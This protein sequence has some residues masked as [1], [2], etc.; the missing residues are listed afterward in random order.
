MG[1]SN[2]TDRRHLVIVGASFS[3]MNLVLQVQKYFKITLIDK[4]E[5]F[6]WTCGTPQ[7][8]L[9]DPEYFENNV[10]AD[11]DQ[12][13]NIDR[14]YGPNVTYV[15]GYLEELVNENIIRIKKTKGKKGDQLQALPSEEIHFDYLAICTGATYSINEDLEGMFNIFSKKEKGELL[16]K[17]RT[18]IDKAKSVVVVGGGPTGVETMAQL[19]MKYGQDKKFGIVTNADHLMVGYPVKAGRSAAAHFESKGIKVYT[20]TKFTPESK[21][22]EE[23]EYAINCVG[24]KFH[25]PFLDK[26]FKD[27]KDARGRIYVNEYFQ[28][29]NVNPCEPPKD[30]HIPHYKVLKNIFC[31]GD[32]ALTRMDEIK[33][34]PAVKASA[35]VVAYNLR[36]LDQGNTRLKEMPY[37]VDMIS[38]VYYDKWKGSMT[39]NRCAFSS[40]CA[41]KMKQD[42][43]KPYFGFLKNRSCGK[44]KFGMLD[45][46][47]ACMGCCFN[48]CCCGCSSRAQRKERRAELRK[49]FNEDN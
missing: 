46:Q 32:A 40:C 34:I 26:N 49:I 36:Q 4:K 18:A 31:F 30:E 38:L 1:G 8:I 20:N 2:T 17:Y 48:L 13:V 33:N 45:K 21:L 12:A 14:I 22:A 24:I 47:A 27:C 28:V 25:S 19:I 3:G 43:E 39:V 5:F 41:L 6:D 9:A 37:G 10:S 15:Q 23:Y 16:T 7:M 29:T 35:P 44:C 42:M 11:L